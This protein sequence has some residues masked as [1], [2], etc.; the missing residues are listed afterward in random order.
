MKRT[1]FLA[2]LLLP[3]L[4]DR[5]AAQLVDLLEQLTD[6]VQQFYAPQIN[7]WRRQHRKLPSP[8][9]KSFANL[10]DEPF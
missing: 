6:C 9:H 2:P 8:P 1:F 7:R 3:Q 5:A 4:S 10:D